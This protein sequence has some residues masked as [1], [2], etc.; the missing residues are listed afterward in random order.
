M[1]R[2]SGDEGHALVRIGGGFSHKA[3]DVVHEPG[4]VV[5]F[6][7]E[8]NTAAKPA[9]NDAFLLLLRLRLLGQNAGMPT[10]GSGCSIRS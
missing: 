5:E 7:W 8:R 2:K 1:K 4:D 6:I 9:T 3:D 10:S